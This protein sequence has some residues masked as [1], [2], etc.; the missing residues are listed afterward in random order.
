MNLSARSTRAPLQGPELEAR[1]PRASCFDRETEQ[2]GLC[3][4][5]VHPTE[6]PGAAVARPWV[7]EAGPVSAHIRQATQDVPVQRRAGAPAP[8]A[9]SAP[10]TL[11]PCPC[12]WWPVP[13]LRPR[14]APTLVHLPSS[15]CSWRYHI[16]S[17]TSAAMGACA[18]ETPADATRQGFF[19]SF[20]ESWGLSAHQHARPRSRARPQARFSSTSL[21]A[22]SAPPCLASGLVRGLGFR[23]LCILPLPS[24]PR[25]RSRSCTRHGASAEHVPCIRAGGSPCGSSRH[26]QGSLG[27]RR[28]PSAAPH[29]ATT[30]ER[31]ALRGDMPRPTTK[32]TKP[33]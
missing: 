20:P 9:G 3:A 13:V 16:S 6:G 14:A 19:L 26:P 5:S 10:W 12:P 32:D 15:V 11:P 28:P 2:I 27:R 8:E 29:A 7:G 1:L 18:P 30:G 24:Q 33:G 21:P 25:T 17:S 23:V 4:P 31:E 22:P